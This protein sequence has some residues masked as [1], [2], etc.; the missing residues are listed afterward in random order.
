MVMTSLESKLKSTNHEIEC[1]CPY[2]KP[3]PIPKKSWGKIIVSP[4][5][6]GRVRYHGPTSDD[7]IW[8]HRWISVSWWT[9]LGLW[10]SG[11]RW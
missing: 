1:N 4:S 10:V 5:S 7:L 2:V 3:T 6:S 8:L 11:L 9:A